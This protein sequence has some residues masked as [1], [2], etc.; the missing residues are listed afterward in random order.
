[1]SEISFLFYFN[2]S[3]PG[4]QNDTF[5]SDALTQWDIYE[6]VIFLSYSLFIP[7][8][9]LLR[10]GFYRDLYLP[11]CL[12]PHVFYFPVLYSVFSLNSTFH[13]CQACSRFLLRICFLFKPILMTQFAIIWL[14]I[15]SLSCSTFIPPLYL[16]ISSESY[17]L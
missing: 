11:V 4:F 9:F 14:N 1:M 12:L 16:T 10:L 7:S 8:V 5:F 17:F 2:H 3:F 15:N 6:F 13:F